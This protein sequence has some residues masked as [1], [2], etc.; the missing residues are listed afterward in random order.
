MLKLQEF[1]LAHDNWEELLSEEPYFLKITRDNGYVMFKYNQLCSDFSI[2]LVREA[3]GIIFKESNWKCVCEKFTKFGNY[4]ESYVPDIDWATASVQEK[5]DGSLIGMFYDNGWHICTNGMIDAFKT[6]T[7][8][9]KYK[10]FGELTIA[11][12]R[13][14]FHDERY[15]F[16]LLDPNCTYM[17]ELVSPYN[18]VVI[19]YE[20]IK[21]YLL[22]IRD[23]R[24]GEECNPE[25]SD[26]RYFFEIPKRYNLHSLE[27]VQ[28]AALALPWSEE[29]YVVCDANFNRVKIKS[30]QY[31]RAHFA[32]NNNV[33]TDRR[34]IDVILAGEVDEFCI[35][36]SEYADRIREIQRRMDTLKYFALKKYEQ[37]KSITDRKELAAKIIHLPVAV[38]G[39]VFKATEFQ[40]TWEEY[41]SSWSLEKWENILRLREDNYVV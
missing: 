4:G 8:N 1:I 31:V 17:F 23:M 6:E 22:G 40:T 36:A 41:T 30:P 7:G 20:E 29:G 25:Y 38:R 27:E 13:A 28:E 34:L 2:P 19:P 24:N 9:A 14:V 32:R 11:A 5:V 21:L 18:R 33:I 3:R 16:E 15:F 35:Y 26:L 39:Y 37:Y 10:N 12:I